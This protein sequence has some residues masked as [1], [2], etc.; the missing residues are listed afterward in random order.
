M[1][2]NSSEMEARYSEKLPCKTCKY[3]LPDVGG[4]SRAESL[5]CQKYPNMS[6][7]KPSAVLFRNEEC[8]FY[9][10]K[11]KTDNFDGEDTRRGVGVLVIKDGKILTGVRNSDSHRGE[12]GGPGGHV[13]D[14]ET[15]E[16]AAI[17]ETEEEFG[18]TPKTLVKMADG[19]Y[20]CTDYTGTV[21]CPDGEM[22]DPK[23][24]SL[25][26]IEDIV[27]SLFQ[28]FAKSIFILL[29]HLSG[30]ERLPYAKDKFDFLS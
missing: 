21:H 3:A 12:I 30:E 14:D 15:D 20:L 23:F 25:D 7:K 18:I 10:E 9:K 17:R 26:E 4:Y 5:F 24:R 11:V 27:E 2:V 19:Q 6:V 16:Y 28:P 8:K 22:R 13:K 29:N 1:G